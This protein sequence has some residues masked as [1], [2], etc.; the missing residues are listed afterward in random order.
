MPLKNLNNKKVIVAMSGGVDSSAVAFLLQQQGFVVEGMTMP[1]SGFQGEDQ[2]KTDPVANARE[3]CQLLGIVHHE[4]QVNPSVQQR[5]VRYFVDEYLKG[6]TPN[7]CVQCNTLIKFK[8]LFEKALELGAD[9]FATG[10]YAR[11]DQDG[12]GYYRLRK[13][14]DLHKDQSYFLYGINPDA[15]PRV[16]FPLGEMTKQQVRQLARDHKLP[17]AERRDSQDICFVPHG[18]YKKVL[19]Q[20]AGENAFVPGPFKDHQGKIVGEH[21]GIGY[22]TVGQRERLGIAL[23]YPAYVYRISLTENTIYVGPRECL[24]SKGLIAADVHLLGLKFSDQ[25]VLL[26]VKIRYNASDISAKVIILDNG[27]V[28]VDFDR[29]QEA[30]TPGQSVVFYQD[31]IVLGGAIIE[32]SIE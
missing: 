16:F 12:N 15:L 29:P 17:C 31:D 23:G 21:Q 30:V 14:L 13:G 3:V 19:R 10:H 7:P 6:R 28:R 27:K 22:Y 8:V 9:F 11:I 25:P 26:S 4:I 20:H 2:A 18:D 32:Q 5:I 1:L 24:L